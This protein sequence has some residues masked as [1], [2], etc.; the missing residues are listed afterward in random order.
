MKRQSLGVTGEPPNAGKLKEEIPSLSC[1]VGPNVSN[2]CWEEC[3]STYIPF[4]IGIE[5]GF[6]G[7]QPSRHANSEAPGLSIVL[8]KEKQGKK[9]RI[10]FIF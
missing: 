9:L 8:Y 5:L 1:H 2:S 6:Y 7:L 10:K 4:D 3:K